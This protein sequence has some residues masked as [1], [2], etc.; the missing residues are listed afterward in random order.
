M[1]AAVWLF[2]NRESEAK[3]TK[4]TK[5][6]VDQFMLASLD[7]L[8]HFKCIWQQQFFEG[9][10]ARR[11]AEENLRKKWL[12]SLGGLPRGTKTPM[13]ERLVSGAPGSVPLG[14]GRRASTLRSRVRVAKRY[15]TWLALAHETASPREVHQMTEYLQARHSEPRCRG[16][17][18]H[19]RF[20]KKQLRLGLHGTVYKELLATATQAREPTRIPW[21]SWKDS[22]PR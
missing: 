13:G 6:A 15:L 22:T 10:A 18:K 7:R 4:S 16:A 17:L 8:V 9:P 20:L 12:G 14:A 3:K 21:R 1:S 5:Q 19:S 2:K 11:D